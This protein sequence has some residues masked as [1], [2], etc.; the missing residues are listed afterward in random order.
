MRESDK[1]GTR[2]LNNSCSVQKR[3]GSLT[4]AKELYF[5]HRRR[6]GGVLQLQAE[7]SRGISQ[8]ARVL[9]LWKEL[10]KGGDWDGGD[11]LLA[12][13]YANLHGGIVRRS[14]KYG[15][16]DS[17]RG[18]LRPW[19]A[20]DSPGAPT[21][22]QDQR[23]CGR[24]PSRGKGKGIAQTAIVKMSSMVGDFVRKGLQRKAINNRGIFH[25]YDRRL[26][27]LTRRSSHRRA[28]AARTEEGTENCEGGKNSRRKPRSPQLRVRGTHVKSDGTKTSGN[29][30]CLE[31]S[32]G[33]SGAASR[34]GPYQNCKKAK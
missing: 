8:K 33:W 31:D 4:V 17:S 14:T 21:Q 15:V 5:A 10:A 16:A 11:F 25:D 23:P 32:L 28:S 20:G 22:C 18:H 26:D 9:N 3:E 7:M 30:R 13:R 34:Q 2:G 27:R 6:E 1:I 24:I 12:D 19:D 29:K